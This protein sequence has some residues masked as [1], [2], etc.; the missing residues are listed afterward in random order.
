[1]YGNYSFV[2]TPDELK[3]LK[4]V[5]SLYS[6]S[7]LM[8]SWEV[9]PGLFREVLPP[10]LEMDRPIV[11]ALMIN[12]DAP[13]FHLYPYSVGMLAL[14]CRFGDIKGMY[15][16]G[17]ILDVKDNQDMTVMLGREIYGYP[18]KNG[19]CF[20]VRTGDE[21]I[22]SIKRHGVE[23]FRAKAIIDEAPFTNATDYIVPSEIGVTTLGAEFHLDYKL[24]AFGDE[25][26]PYRALEFSNPRL[27]HTKVETRVVSEEICKSAAV[28]IRPS[29]DDPWI[30]LAPKGKVEAVY[31]VFDCRL[32]CNQLDKIYEG[33]DAKNIVPYLFARMDYLIP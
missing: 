1:M 29:K 2:R 27:V 24:D 14:S 17:M 33:E 20:I 5:D 19:S 22:A 31:K 23:V 13:G 30:Q 10:G 15:P 32:M 16:I 4:E 26:T 18:K 25:K 3:K 6:S 21:I 8:L 28:T 11:T 7:G 12:H 9:D